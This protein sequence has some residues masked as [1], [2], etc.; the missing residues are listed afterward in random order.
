MVFLAGDIGGTKTNLALFD[1]NL[2]I[3]REKKYSSQGHA[4]LEEI[5]EEFGEDGDPE[6]K[7]MSFG[8]AGPIKDGIC[9]TTNLP[10]V[11]DSHK[12]KGQ[13]GMDAVYLLNDL[14]SNAWGIKVL[15]PSDLY[16]LNEGH[17]HVEGNEALVSAGTGLGEAGLYYNGRDHIP[18]ACEGGHCD[19]APRDAHEVALF[20]YLKRKYGFHVSYERILSGRGMIDLYEFLLEDKGGSKPKSYEEREAQG[21]DPARIITELGL[22]KE[23]PLCAETLEMF[24]SIYGSECGNTALKFMAL[25]GLYI[26]GG[27][28]PKILEAMQAGGFMESF[29]NKGRFRELLSQIPV[30]IVLNDKTALLGAAYFC[31]RIK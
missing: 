18:F 5:I 22:S 2:K 29:I 1:E 12:M 23:D 26:G 16:V 24:V 7:K 28:A 31:N 15:E 19:F 25:H 20:E 11:I 4:S 17:P 14:E 9:R 6:I 8:I 3:L 30:R 10:W 21:E 27:I 13:F